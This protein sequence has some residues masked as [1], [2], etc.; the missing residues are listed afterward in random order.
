LCCG[1][2]PG[3]LCCGGWPGTGWA[4]AAPGA[5]PWTIR[6]A[7]STVGGGTFCFINWTRRAAMENF[8]MCCFM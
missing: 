5:C 4:G 1:G 8:P 7:W 6:I 3:G 2:W